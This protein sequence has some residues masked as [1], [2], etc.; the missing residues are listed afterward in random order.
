MPQSL[1]SGGNEAKTQSYIFDWS[2]LTFQEVGW[3]DSG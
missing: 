2:L 1:L 3:S